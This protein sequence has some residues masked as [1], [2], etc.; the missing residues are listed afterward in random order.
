MSEKS[1]VI[2]IGDLVK[3]RDFKSLSRRCQG[4]YE[5]SWMSGKEGLVMSIGPLWNYDWCK[6]YRDAASILFCPADNYG[7]AWESKVAIENLILLKK[8]NGRYPRMGFEYPIPPAIERLCRLYDWDWKMRHH[9]HSHEGFSNA[10]T[11]LAWVYIKN[12][13]RC[14]S[15]VVSQRRKNGTIN[16]DKVRKIFY[17]HNLRVDDWAFNYPIDL[18]ELLNHSLITRWKPKV[19]WLEVAGNL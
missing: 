10:A 1:E 3:V 12:D 5:D 11:Y 13:Q 17:Q 8:G 15:A 14:L 9:D 2:E 6:H 16:P 4:Q 18:P 19:N 7:D